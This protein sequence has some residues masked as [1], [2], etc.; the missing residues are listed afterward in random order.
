MPVGDHYRMQHSYSVNGR[1]C[2]NTY[3]WQLI[4]PTAGTDESADLLLAFASVVTVNLL[5][6]WSSEVRSCTLEAWSLENTLPPAKTVIVNSVGA[7]G[8]PACPANK[9]IKIALRQ[10]ALS[11]RTNGE[12]RIA[13]IPEA[14]TDG[15]SYNGLA[16]HGAAFAALINAFTVGLDTPPGGAGKWRLKIASSGAEAQAAPPFP[17]YNDV[18]AA[19]VRSLI[20]SDRRRTS[21]HEFVSP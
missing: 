15:N 3:I 20:Y 10:A 11:A 6:I 18:V 12:L 16:I 1:G 14:E 5:D 4:D 13:G 21:R 8:T 19:D 2:S 9:N 17:H 7:I